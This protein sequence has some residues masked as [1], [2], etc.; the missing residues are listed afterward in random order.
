MGQEQEG[1][2][3]GKIFPPYQ[4]NEEL[5]AGAAPHAVF[6]H[7]LPAHRG[8]EIT[9]GIIDSV[10]SVVFDQAESRLH[11]QKAVLTLLLGGEKN[12]IPVRSVHA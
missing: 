5:V 10:R 11:A 12:R 7:C 4:V 8:E 6:M 9:D 3:R 1:E 2:E